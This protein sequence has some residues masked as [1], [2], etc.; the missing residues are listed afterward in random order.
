MLDCFDGRMLTVFYESN[1]VLVGNVDH[2]LNCLN[3]CIDQ[4]VNV[5][6]FYIFDDSSGHRLQLCLDNAHH[7][8]EVSWFFDI[9]SSDCRS[10][11]NAIAFDNIHNNLK[12][13]KSA[14]IYNFFCESPWDKH[15][16][17]EAIKAISNADW[18]RLGE[19]TH[20]MSMDIHLYVAK[21]LERSLLSE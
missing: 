19:I 7:I 9:N 8:K 2:L 3:I 16:R 18:G 17:A 21:L 1:I 5:N 14:A 12:S 15:Q 20:F 11:I 4:G 13:S 10:F 6:A